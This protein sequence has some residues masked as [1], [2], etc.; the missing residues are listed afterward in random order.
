MPTGFPSRDKRFGMLEEQLEIVTGL[1]GTPVG[2]RFSFTGRHYTLVDSPALPKP[3]QPRIPVIV[4]G[5]G[6][7]RT[8]AL[9]ARFASEYNLGFHSYARMREQAELVRDAC[10]AIGRDPDELVLSVALVLCVGKDETELARR[11]AA[12]GRKPGD[13]RKE[14]FAGTPGE[15]VERIGRYAELGVTRCYLQT[16]DLS[17]I[18]HLELVASEV[19]PQLR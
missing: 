3:A 7:T 14:D 17:D 12:I 10:A 4:G 9:A 19:A 5:G 13:L 16:L 15:V 18:D 2:E 11:A 6:R 8:P 1:W